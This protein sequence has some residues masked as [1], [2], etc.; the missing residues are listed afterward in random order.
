MRKLIKSIEF[1]FIAA[2]SFTGW[3]THGFSWVWAVVIFGGYVAINLT[4]WA[5]RALYEVRDEIKG[6]AKKSKK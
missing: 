1:V 5:N 4:G 3:F 2:V 6:K